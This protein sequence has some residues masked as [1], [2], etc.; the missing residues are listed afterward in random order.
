MRLALWTSGCRYASGVSRTPAGSSPDCLV[1]WALL[2]VIPDGAGP[3][4]DATV[5]SS[6]FT[7]EPGI[8]ERARNRSKRDNAQ[9][10]QIDRTSRLAA[11]S[12]PRNSFLKASGSYENKE[13]KR[14]RRERCRFQV[15][16]KCARRYRVSLF[17]D[18]YDASLYQQMFIKKFYSIREHTH[19]HIFLYKITY[20][21]LDYIYIVRYKIWQLLFN[22]RLNNFIMYFICIMYYVLRILLRMCNNMQEM[23]VV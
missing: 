15:L 12:M 2:M 4:G 22:Q 1:S 16:N 20:Y 8:S 14:K 13:K 23:N 10:K 19:T 21:F 6:P 7:I 11:V 3:Q 17:C 9:S 5:S 18:K